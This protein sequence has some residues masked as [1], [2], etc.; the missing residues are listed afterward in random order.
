MV[1]FLKL[2]STLTKETL[3]KLMA[4]FLLL[5]T[6]SRV[7]ISKMIFDICDKI[8]IPLKCQNLIVNL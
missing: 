3:R 7:E 6:K 5:P 1:F 2:T 4:G 8:K